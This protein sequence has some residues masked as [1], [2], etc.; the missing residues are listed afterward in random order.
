MATITAESSAARTSHES[1]GEAETGADG[2]SG[3][4]PSGAPVEVFFFGVFA[5][6]TSPYL[7]AVLNS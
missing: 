6:F 1:R 5:F 2:E 7:A 3:R 4:A